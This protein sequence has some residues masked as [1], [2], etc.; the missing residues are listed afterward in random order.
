MADPG[1]PLLVISALDT[2]RFGVRVAKSEPAAAEV[3]EAVRLARAEGVDVV[4][5]RTPTEDIVAAHAV[6][7]RGGRLMDTLVAYERALSLLPDEAAAADVEI[8]EAGPVDGSVVADL[9]REAFRGY[10]GHY[11]ADPRLDEAA[12]DEVYASWAERSC[13]EPGVADAVLVARRG[14]DLLGFTAL[15]LDGE[16]AVGTLDG[17]APA[18]RGRGVYTALG[19][20]RMRKAADLGAT[21]M[22]VT[23]HLANAGAQRGLQRLGFVA[24]W[25]QHTFHLW[26]DE[27]GRMAP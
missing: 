26:L 18:A 10:V 14:A 25:S 9:A 21:R 22:L 17:V 20:A 4:F 27:A 16:Q 1:R 23:T 11:H 8:A 6:E 7:T 5:F 13:A 19:V 24:T 12:C 3:E 2:E 15:K